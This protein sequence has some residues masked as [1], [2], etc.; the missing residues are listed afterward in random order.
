[1]VRNMI[2]DNAYRIPGT[3]KVKAIFIYYATSKRLVDLSNPCCVI[4]KFTMDAVVSAGIL[5]DDNIKHVTD[6]QY[7]YGGV[8]RNNPRCDFF[9]V[10]QTN[11]GYNPSCSNHC[12]WIRRN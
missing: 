11:K 7:K 12:G 6:V 3:T 8:D 10:K 2:P 9:L 4:D 1:M 5:V